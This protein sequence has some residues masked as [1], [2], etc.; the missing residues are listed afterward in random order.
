MSWLLDPTISHLNHGS[1]G[2]V[3]GPVLDAQNAWRRHIEANPTAFMAGELPAHID[4]VRNLLAGL[5][6]ADP[7]GLVFVRNATTGVSAVLGSV[8]FRPGDRI[9]VTDHGYNACRN[10]V[11]FVAERT[12]A[13]VVTVRIPFP[14]EGPDQVVSAVLDRVD[15]NTRLVLVDHVTSPTALI[16]PIE[17][18]VAALE[19]SVPVLVDGAH[20][21]GML[22]LRLDRLGASWYVGNCHKWLCAP[23]GVGFLWAREDRRDGLYPPVI[24]HGWSRPEPERFHAM[25]DWTG[26]DDPTP[27]LSLPVAIEFLAAHGGLE[28]VMA[29]NRRLALAGRAALLDALGVEPPAPVD[30]IG[31]MA[32]VPLPRSERPADDLVDP[33]TR[34]LRDIHRIEVPVFYW[35]EPPHRVV[36]I[37]AHL[38]NRPTEY[39]RLAEALTVELG[40][41]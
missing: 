5:V 22:P 35:P 20:G 30:M 13:E 38:Y 36:R 17:E 25:F 24:S 7:A 28:E 29:H 31:S 3:P 4:R 21:P 23:R 26:T 11:R 8:G 41:G 18:L 40:G 2:A 9:L 33:L 12:G 37:S 32:S 10:A 16:L 15:S 19:P 39:R 1:F 27:I 14:L 34:R 6:G